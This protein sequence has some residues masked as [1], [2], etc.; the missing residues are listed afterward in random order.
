MS[1]RNPFASMLYRLSALLSQRVS[2][3]DGFFKEIALM[4]R[5][6]REV[7]AVLYFLE[8][9]DF[10]NK[11]ISNM[12]IEAILNEIVMPL[13]QRLG[14]ARFKADVLTHLGYKVGQDYDL[15]EMDMT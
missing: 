7:Y 3:A 1:G 11:D 4:D 8:E 13:M 9:S 10:L 15:V 5:K 6:E 12:S 2:K 14:Q